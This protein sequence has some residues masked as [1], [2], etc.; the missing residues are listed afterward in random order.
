M[1][2]NPVNPQHNLK[3]THITVTESTVH[4]QHQNH[5]ANSSQ[6]RA[7][8]TVTTT[9]T[10]KD[11]AWPK[12]KILNARILEHSGNYMHHYYYH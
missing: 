10:H 2:L 6:N 9:Q 1:V 4:F 3:D 11:S 5:S 12:L 8:L 7:L